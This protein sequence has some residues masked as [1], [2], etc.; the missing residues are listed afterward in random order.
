MKN[1]FSSEFGDFIGFNLKFHG[2]N[3]CFLLL[4]V[5]KM[6]KCILWLLNQTDYNY[7]VQLV[8]SKVIYFELPHEKKMLDIPT[9]K[10]LVGIN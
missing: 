6:M 8:T 1:I 4:L 3:G 7:Y 5:G 10:K 2:V 9:S